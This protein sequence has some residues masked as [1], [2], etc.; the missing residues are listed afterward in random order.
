MN[1][2]FKQLNQFTIK[3]NLIV[4]LSHGT[5]CK[6]FQ[7]IFNIKVHINNQQIDTSMINKE[8]QP[9]FENGPYSN[10]G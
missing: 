4:S 6:I 10:Q 3:S 5:D 2:L 8:V 1:F 9:V 7:H